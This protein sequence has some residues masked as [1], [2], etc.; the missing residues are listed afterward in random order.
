MN[1][2]QRLQA[3]KLSQKQNRKRSK[4][5]CAIVG[6]C[7]KTEK[8]LSDSSIHCDNNMHHICLDCLIP[9]V[10]AK[11]DKLENRPVN[12]FMCPCNFDQSGQMTGTF[13]SRC[14]IPLDEMLKLIGKHS[15]DNHMA[16]SLMD[17][18]VTITLE[19]CYDKGFGEGL[20]IGMLATKYP[21]I[22][23]IVEMVEAVDENGRKGQF[24]TCIKCGNGPIRIDGCS[25]MSTHHGDQDSTGR[26]NMNNTCSK[27]GNFQSE[28]SQAWKPYHLPSLDSL[29]RLDDPDANTDVEDDDLSD[30]SPMEVVD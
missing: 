19:N 5:F 13:R 18:L 8:L 30:S 16:S 22:L 27:C 20:R 21:E 15:H 2:F 3:E 9:Y 28:R 7:D 24:Y 25:N 12:K 4:H 23:D 17:R 29:L 1:T 6:S 26:G 14:H 11:L 10:N